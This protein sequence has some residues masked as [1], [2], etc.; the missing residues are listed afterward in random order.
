[1]SEKKSVE[2]LRLFRFEDGWAGE[3]HGVNIY[4]RVYRVV[5]ET[6]QGYWIAPMTG[7]YAGDKPKFM[8]K[9]A[10]RRFAWPT[11]REAMDSFLA[12]KQRQREILRA[13]LDRARCAY[14][15]GKRLLAKGNIEGAIL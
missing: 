8:L 3:R 6:D 14:D 10:H 12:R 2:R 11:K 4:L 7:Y 1:M 13:Q 15:Q 9:K 5:R